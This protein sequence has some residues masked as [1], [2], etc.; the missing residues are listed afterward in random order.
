MTVQTMRNLDRFVG[1][2]CCWILAVVLRLLP[3]NKT[4]RNRSA[5]YPRRQVL[6]SRKHHPLDGCSLDVEEAFSPGDDYVSFIRIK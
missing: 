4:Q 1:V 3:P 2:P 5:Q 6:W